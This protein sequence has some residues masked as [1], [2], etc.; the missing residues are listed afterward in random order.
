[1]GGR[2]NWERCISMYLISCF[3]FSLE[4][5]TMRIWKKVKKN[6]FANNTYQLLPSDLS[7]LLITQMEVTFSPLKRSLKIPKRVTGKN[8]VPSNFFLTSFGM[9][10]KWPE[11]LKR[12][13]KRDQPKVWSRMESPGRWVMVCFSLGRDEGLGKYCWLGPG[14]WLN[15]SNWKIWNIVKLDHLPRG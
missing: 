3:L 10:K 11:K 14:G 6:T 5:Q 1:M 13:R 15:Q 2:R 4:T 8:L 7:D 9:L 12:Q